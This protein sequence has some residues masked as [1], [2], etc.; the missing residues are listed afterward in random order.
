MYISDRIIDSNLLGALDARIPL[1]P[2]PK[3]AE[4]VWKLARRG[5]DKRLLAA[6]AFLAARTGPNRMDA[7]QLSHIIFTSAFAVYKTLAI[8]HLVA[9]YFIVAR[10]ADLHNAWPIDTYFNT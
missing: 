7:L 9:A 4:R 2:M 1:L 3:C 8:S 6:H 10:E 5:D